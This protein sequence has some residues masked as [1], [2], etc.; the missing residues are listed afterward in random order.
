MPLYF[1]FR[2]A[3]FCKRWN[4]QIGQIKIKRLWF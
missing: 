3:L 4:F 2:I 1:N